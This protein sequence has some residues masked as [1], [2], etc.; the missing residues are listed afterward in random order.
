MN[1]RLRSGDRKLRSSLQK[2]EM[3]HI[4]PAPTTTKPK[5]KMRFSET[6]DQSCGVSNADQPI[7]SD[8]L[9]ENQTANAN[10]TD[11]SI[12]MI[13]LLESVAASNTQTQQQIAIEVEQL[14][15]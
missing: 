9:L 11:S 1:H 10:E 4:P 3:S 14:A 13:D 8:H 7:Q 5:K 12:E 6:D 2:S 15:S